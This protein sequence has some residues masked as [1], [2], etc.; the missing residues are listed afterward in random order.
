MKYGLTLSLFLG[1]IS[2]DAA[3]LRLQQHH[4]H[5]HGHHKHQKLAQYDGDKQD[6][7]PDCQPGRDPWAQATGGAGTG[8][9]YPGVGIGCQGFAQKSSKAGYDGDSQAWVDDC[10][11]GRNPF[12]PGNGNAGTVT[13]YPGVGIECQGFNKKK[14]QSR[15]QYD[16]DKQDWVEACDPAQD[17]WAQ[18]N[19]SG[20]GTYKDEKTGGSFPGVGVECQGFAQKKSKSGY[21]G[22]SQAW[23]D[24]CAPGRNPFIPGNGNAGTAGSYPGVGIECQGFNKKNTQKLAQYDGDS[25]AWV[26]DCAPGRN[27]WIQADGQAGTGGSYPGVGINCQGFAQK[28]VKKSHKL[29]QY[30]GDSQAWI[31]DCAPGRDPWIQA[32]GQAGTG[33]SYPGVGI[34]CQ[35]FAQKKSKSLAQYDGDSQAWVDQCDPTQDTVAQ[36]NPS[37]AGTYDNPEN[38]GSFKGVGVECQ[39]FA[40]K[41]SKSLAQYDGDSQAWVDLCDPTQETTAQKNPS[42]AG[43]YNGPKTKGSF[44]G[45]GIEC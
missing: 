13:S 3:A 1:L 44:P 2:K 7:V 9:S 23:V 18:K 38:H 21:D 33:G 22:D 19:P 36:K 25:Q 6:W 20:A 30:D 32:D 39:G 4:H 10:A 16:G 35:G 43:T 31:D 45:V 11:P 17:P 12:I 24:D 26:D 40:Q 37:G 29:V 41:K 5:H 27:P 8:G 42:G 28:K 15:A 34:N 14:L